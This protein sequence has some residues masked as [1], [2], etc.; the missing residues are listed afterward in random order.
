MISGCQ[1]PSC[2]VNSQDVVTRSTES[3]HNLDAAGDRDVA[4]FTR[5]AKQDG[6]AHEKKL[7][8]LT[9]SRSQCNVPAE[10]TS[11]SLIVLCGKNLCRAFFAGG[12]AK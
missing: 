4:L 7:C 1:K 6:Y 12:A 11:I 2:G 10:L 9:I 5:S 3:L 8:S